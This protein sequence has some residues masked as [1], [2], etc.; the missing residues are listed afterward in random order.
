MSTILV[1]IIIR[2]FF[3]KIQTKL[4]KINI[5]VTIINVSFLIFQ[6]KNKLNLCLNFNEYQPIYA[7][8]PYAY[9]KEYTDDLRVQPISINIKNQ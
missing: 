9:Q 7:Y 4:T 3:R 2:F 6:P 8:K 5:E 1:C